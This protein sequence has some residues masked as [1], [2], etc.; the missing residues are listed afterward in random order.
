MEKV[1][2]LSMRNASCALRRDVLSIGCN[3]SGMSSMS[4]ID[5]PGRLKWD[6]TAAVAFALSGVFVVCQ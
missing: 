5:W 3:S 4:V 2:P 6:G 1:L